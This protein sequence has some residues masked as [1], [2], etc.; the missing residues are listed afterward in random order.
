MIVKMAATAEALCVRKTANLTQAPFAYRF[1]ASAA[2]RPDTFLADLPTAAPKLRALLDTLA[3]LDARDLARDGVRYKHL[4]YSDLKPAQYGAKAIVSA[5]VASGWKHAYHG[6]QHSASAASA[7]SKG[8]VCAYLASGAVYGQPLL[9]RTKRALLERFNAR[10]TNVYGD[11]IRIL[12]IDGGFKEG[13]DVFDIRYIHILEPAL[14]PAAQTQVVGRGART[15]GQAGLTFQPGIGWPL[16]VFVYDVRLPTGLGLHEL[17][18]RYTPLRLEDVHLAADLEAATL[19]AAIDYPLT[20]TLFRSQRPPITRGGSDPNPVMCQTDKC[21][22]VRPTRDVPVALPLLL[23][24]YYT[25]HAPPPLP[26]KRLLNKGTPRL[27]EALCS[28]LSSTPA[29]CRQVRALHADPAA[30]FRTHASRFAALVRDPP[31]TLPG[32]ARRALLKAIYAYIPTLRPRRA[33]P[34]PPVPEHPFEGHNDSHRYITTH[35][36]PRFAW[37]EIRVENHCL[38]AVAPIKA[39]SAAQAPPASEAQANKKEPITFHPTQEFIRHYFTPANPYK[40][41]L[42]WHSV[43]TGT[44]CTAIATATTAFEPAG[45]TIL[46]VTR[47]TLK[48]DMLKN[49]FDN[50]CHVLLRDIP[51][52]EE[53]E[54]RRAL[55][56]K[57]WAIQPLSY[58]Q[59]SNAIKGQNDAGDILRRRNGTVD[60]LR[61]TLIIL[62]ECHKLYETSSDLIP[63]ERPDNFQS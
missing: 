36:T 12:V 2:F 47:T 51:I 42:L 39:Q 5:L 45:Y 21:G 25:V 19:S 23:A 20:Q 61:K 48:Q 59:F 57:A 60:P 16:H 33:A 44:T 55:L 31:M 3:E 62:D 15:C 4:I 9:A 26:S 1:D 49:I 52:P 29:Y 7:A 10:P 28:V 35:Y 41:M 14:T 27:R 46:W 54:R 43:G 58:R 34:A 6:A 38:G 32:A 8:N 24:A 40:G 53:R 37:P 13:I 11:D 18:L 50:V 63:Q 30:F 17:A 56:S 22:R